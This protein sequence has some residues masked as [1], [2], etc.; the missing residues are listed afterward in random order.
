M[1]KLFII[2]AMAV[3][4]ITTANAQEFKVGAKAGF[5]LSS[6][7]EPEYSIIGTGTAKFNT[8]YR[9]GFHFGAFIEYGFNEKLWV[10]AGIDYAFQG[11][12]LKSL[13]V[14]AGPLSGK[15]DLNSSSKLAIQQLNV[16]L[17]FK[18]DI[19]GFRPKVGVNLGFLSKVEFEAEPANNSNFISKLNYSL[20]PDKNFDLG[21]GFGAEY[22]LDSGLFFDA[23]F[24]LGL[25]ELSTKDY[26]KDGKNWVPMKFKNRVFQIGVGYKF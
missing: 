20:T 7:S 18:Y 6:V 17:W 26:S 13:E 15:V 5:L 2:A 1:K 19:N 23:T 8:A 24:N 10:E 9:P 12:N 3:A 22:N 4:A 14:S 21:L 16:P 25:T 11:A